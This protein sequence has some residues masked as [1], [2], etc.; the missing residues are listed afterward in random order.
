MKPIIFSLAFIFL[1]AGHGMAQSADPQKQSKLF[2]KVRQL[3]SKSPGSPV[4]VV[5]VISTRF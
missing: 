1:L 5:P 4:P 2:R 3:S